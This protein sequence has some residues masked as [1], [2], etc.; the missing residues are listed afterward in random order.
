VSFGIQIEIS[1]Q[2]ETSSP[3]AKSIN[4]I[5]L[6]LLVVGVATSP[7]ETKG[8]Y[9]EKARKYPKKKNE[10]IATEIRAYF[11][12]FLLVNFGIINHQILF[13]F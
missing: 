6:V 12:P 5:V 13:N 4:L 3:V 1:T 7:V 9:G 11:L 2:S 10:I 8:E